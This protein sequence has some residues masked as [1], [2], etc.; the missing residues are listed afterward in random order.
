MNLQHARITEL[1]Q[2]LKLEPIGAEWPHLAQQ[3]AAAE[4]SFGEFLERLLTLEGD[5]RA[6][7]TRTTLL[8]LAKL[9]AVK[10]LEQYDFAFATGAPRA[11]LQE[12]AA[13]SFI[14]RAENIVL[15]GPSGVGKSHLATALAYR[16]VMAG[17]KTRFIGADVISGGDGNDTITGGSGIDTI[18][19]GDGSDVVTYASVAESSGVNADTVSDFVSG[20]DALRFTLNVGGAAAVNINVSGFSTVANFSDGLVSLGGT[21]SGQ[22]YGDGF[23]STADGKLHIDTNGDGQINQSNDYSV[24]VGS[25]AASDLEFVIT[26]SSAADTIVG[27]ARADTITGGAGV[28]TITSGGGDDVITDLNAGG[29][30]DVLVFSGTETIA[31][32]TTGTFATAAGVTSDYSSSAVTG[33]VTFTETDADSTA[34]PVVTRWTLA[35]KIA[36]VQADTT[37]NVADKVSMFVHGDDAYVY[38]SGA[39]TGSADNQL[40]KIEGGSALNK[41]DVTNASG[42]TLESDSTISTAIAFTTT[43]AAYTGVGNT[44]D[45]FSVLAWSG[46]N[47]E[48]VATYRTLGDQWDMIGWAGATAATFTATD[49]AITAYLTANPGARSFSDDYTWGATYTAAAVT[50]TIDENAATGDMVL[51]ADAWSVYYDTTLGFAL[52]GGSGDDMI[53]GTQDN[54]TLTGNAGNDFILAGNG[55]DGINGGAGSD[56][57]YGGAG[58]DT[59]TVTTTANDGADT[60]VGRSG[61]DTIA[62]T[63][64]STIVFTATDG[65]ISEIETITLGAAAS[66]TL[67][68]Q[69]EAFTITASTGNETVV[70]GSGADTITGGAGADS[71][72]G[73]AGADRIVAD[74]DDV[75]IDGGADTDTMALAANATFTAA[76]LANIETVEL[77][78]GVDLT[79][80]YLDVTGAN[81]IATVTGVAGGTAEKLIVVGASVGGGVAVSLDYSAA[82]LTLTNVLLEVQ[83]GSD[84]EA[85]T[86]TA[87]ADTISGGAGADFIN[88]GTVLIAGDT[89]GDAGDLAG[90]LASDRI[91]FNAAEDTFQ[92]SETIF[93][94]MGNGVSG[95]GFALNAAQFR[96][97]GGTGDTLAGAN[98]DNTGNGAIV[99]DT[100]NNDLYFIEAGVDLTNALTDTIGELVTAGNAIKIADVTLT[101]V[102]TAANFAIIG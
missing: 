5:A 59:F 77:G 78:S 36:A 4:Q 20:T 28:D 54:D 89:A 31:A 18:S 91:T 2:S 38:Y 96:S 57:L 41:I 24:I 17:I 3:A 10:T 30:T 35:N 44:A 75:L 43:A 1:C 85:I 37:L 6:E 58:A 93:G 74:D 72:T 67:T 100:A 46:S 8:K 97:A 32:A 88:F 98:I 86:G 82:Y 60:L 102:L 55:D 29:A 95:A 53:F 51:A 79:V 84:A 42:F 94:I 15:L 26:G 19:T 62:V 40:I 14:E 50:R 101:G 61:S 76:Q 90:S 68:G 66:V 25:V 9:P 65:N 92:L 7:R 49:A 87:G 70:G 45:S 63:A 11:Q 16:A 47:G 52:T 81:N 73:G 27:G 12:L 71:L 21:S 13:L 83:G 56:V 99:Y 33:F 39:T 34:N 48:V 80:N 69:T 22:V 23:Y 64:G